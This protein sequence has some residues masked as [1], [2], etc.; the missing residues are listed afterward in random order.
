MWQGSDGDTWPRAQS[1]WNTAV[2]SER[3]GLTEV[4]DTGIDMRC[5]SVRPRPVAIGP[6]PVGTP[7]VLVVPNTMSTK[8]AVTTISVIATDSRPKPPGE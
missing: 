3:A 1:P 7:L 2:A 4:F 6:K 8:I 5:T